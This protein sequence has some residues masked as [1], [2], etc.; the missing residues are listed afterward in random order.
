MSRKEGV[1]MFGKILKGIR[2][3]KGLTQQQLGNIIGIYQ[4]SICRLEKDDYPPSYPTLVALV[5]KAKVK[6]AELF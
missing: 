4:Q 1:E 6:P 2:Q 5:E 3:Q